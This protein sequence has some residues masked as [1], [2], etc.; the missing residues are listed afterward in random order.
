MYYDKAF[1]VLIKVSSDILRNNSRSMSLFEKTPSFKKI[2]KTY[3]V[4]VF[5]INTKVDML[6][7]IKVDM[8]EASIKKRELLSF[9]GSGTQF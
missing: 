6:I 7:N 8:L 1:V 2:D 4:K 9:G 3:M 5:K